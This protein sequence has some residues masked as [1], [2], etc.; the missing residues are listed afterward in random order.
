MFELDELNR[1][2]FQEGD[3]KHIF[4]LVQQSLNQQDYEESDFVEMHLSEEIDFVKVSGEQMGEAHDRRSKLFKDRLRTILRLR[5][6][7]I[8]DRLREIY[9][10]QN[11]TD[12]MTYSSDEANVLYLDLIETRRKIDNALLSPETGGSGKI[13][14][15]PGIYRSQRS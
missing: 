11:E 14:N 10:L 2:D 7:N 13:G 3:H 8:E 15:I 1:D 12:Q 6:N 5:R 9:F 4:D